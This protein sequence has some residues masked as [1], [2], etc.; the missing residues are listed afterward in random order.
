MG[1]FIFYL[2]LA[3]LI[4]WLIKGRYSAKEAAPPKEASEDM[5]RCAYCNIYLPKG[6]AKRQKSS[7]LPE[8][9]CNECGNKWQ[10]SKDR[11][12][13]CRK[14]C[15]YSEHKDAN[16]TGKPYPKGTPA[17]SWKAY[18]QAYPPKQQAFFDRRDALKGAGVAKKL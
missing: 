1:K 5:V 18:G 12:H 8:W 16:K 10:D 9:Q 4:Y 11:P 14:E 17:L 6:E 3:L 13:R 2:L 15:I 7:D